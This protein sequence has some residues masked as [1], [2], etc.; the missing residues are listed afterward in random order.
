MEIVVARYLPQPKSTISHCAFNDKFAFHILEDVDRGLKQTDS[1][2]HIK[3]V[4]VYGETAIPYGRYEVIVSMSNRFG[5]RLPELLNVPGWEGVRM[6]RGNHSIDTL[7]CLLM[8]EYVEGAN[9]WIS[10]SEGSEALTMDILERCVDRKEKIWITI[11]KD[12]S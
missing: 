9:D 4:K 10:Q 3:A 12:F 1:L 8:G 6:H 5:R 2:D 7:G 11:K